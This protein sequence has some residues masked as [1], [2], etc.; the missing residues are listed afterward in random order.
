MDSDRR[1]GKYQDNKEHNVQWGQAPSNE[2]L[3]DG[4]VEIV[5]DENDAVKAVVSK[6]TTRQT[7]LSNYAGDDVVE[8]ASDKDEYPNNRY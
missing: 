8:Y 2:V 3:G 4:K 7:Y 1:F 5:S 6:P